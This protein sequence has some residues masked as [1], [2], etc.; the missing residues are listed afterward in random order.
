M[1]VAAG[2]VVARVIDV[3]DPPPRRL[4]PNDPWQFAARE[5][6]RE[7]SQL[8]RKGRAEP[9]APHFTSLMALAD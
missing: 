6:S 1:R 5:R 3:G 4:R 9:A 8:F 2:V 7:T